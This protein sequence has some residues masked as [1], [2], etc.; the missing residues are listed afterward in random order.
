MYL[1]HQASQKSERLL[2]PLVMFLADFSNF[3]N[4]SYM[5]RQIVI[6]GDFGVG[7]GGHSR[8]TSEQGPGEIRQLGEFGTNSGIDEVK[9]GAFDFAKI[10]CHFSI[11]QTTENAMCHITT[12]PNSIGCKYLG[13]LGPCWTFRRGNAQEWQKNLGQKMKSKDA[14]ALPFDRPFFYPRFFTYLNSA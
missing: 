9:Y 3:T 4:D 6:V 14:S 13:Q 7:F 8:F 5:K 1:L 12:H 11:P 10:G 2:V